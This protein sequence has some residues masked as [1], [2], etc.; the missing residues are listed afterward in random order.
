MN[1]VD[2]LK[3]MILVL[4]A[5]VEESVILA[6]KS[7]QTR[8]EE[9]AL[10]VIRGDYDVDQAEVEVEEEALKILALH[11][12]VATDL[13]FL[14]AVLKINNDLERIGDLATNIAK[15]AVKIC[16]EPAL[17]VSDELNQA[18]T[19]VRDMVHE[20]LNAFVNFDAEPA[21]V[22]CASDAEVDRLCKEV[23]RFVE[24][25]IRQNPSCLSGCLDMLLAS[26]NIERI[27]DHATN[28]AED[29]IYLV[30][31]VIVRH[32][33]TEGKN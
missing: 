17:A 20:S 11:Q 7:L 2:K 6:V 9:L 3:K 27:G 18:A 16:K 26:R 33:P 5:Q 15:R 31:G 14:T 25:K 30:E 32:R 29:V 21:R 1:E 28:I 23:R 22:V 4:S 12:P 19:Q 24:E 10:Q 13:R 8:D